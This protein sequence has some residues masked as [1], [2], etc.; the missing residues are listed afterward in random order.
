MI[1]RSA[2]DFDASPVSPSPVVQTERIVSLDVLRGFALLG[3]LVV[4]VQSFSM[5]SA[6]YLNPTAQGDLNGANRGVWL[7][8]HILFDTKFMTIFSM[9]FGAGIVLMA[10]RAR[11]AGRS[12]IGLHHRRM[13]W[14]MLLGILH[15]HL[16]WYGDILFLYGVCGLVVY[17]FWRLRPSFLF[18]AGFVFLGV[19]TGISLLSGWSMPYWTDEQLAEIT[20]DWQPSPQLAEITMDWQPSPDVVDAELAAYRGDWL[21]QMAHRVPA[22]IKFETLILFVWGFWRA[23]GMMLVGM[24]LFKMG[25]FSAQ[26]SKRFYSSWIASA[27][28]IGIPVILYGVRQNFAFDWDVRY[29]F[30]F[31]PLHNYWAGIAVSLGYVGLVM[32]ACRSG[33]AKAVQRV[34]AAV[35]QTAL[36]NYLLQTIICTT[37]F[38]GHGLG[39]FGSV[40][41]L[42][43]L[44][45]VVAVWT[46][47]LV[48]SPMWMRHFRFGPFEWLWRTLTYLRWQPMRRVCQ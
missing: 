19:G 20:M 14:L 2:S 26:Q 45:V 39:W 31:G 4:N 18:L 42:G 40:E 47:G 44:G 30:F 16:L 23:G 10:E 5:I 3:I 25:V 34:L 35:G 29:S 1:Y 6:A 8:T 15:A 28:L 36:S 32:L 38:Y 9:L 7:L 43:Q 41:R 12:A 11:T 37:I 48:V 27:A 13:F 21:D 46:V 24:A 17:W 22:A 33:V